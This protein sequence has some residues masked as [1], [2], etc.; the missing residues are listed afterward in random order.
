MSVTVD[1][2]VEAGEVYRRLDI[3][4]TG[5]SSTAWAAW[6]SGV[7]GP[8]LQERAEMR[9][10]NEG[11]DAVGMWQSL[12]PSTI[13]IRAQQ[14]FPP[15]PIN[16]RTGELERLLT[17]DPVVAAPIGPVAELAFPAMP[18]GELKEKL[19]TAQQ[20]KAHPKTPPRPVVGLSGIDL[21]FMLSAMSVYANKVTGFSL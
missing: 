19:K 12:K 2:K 21:M 7:M 5:F 13:R 20:G 18:G 16:H 17:E 10:A 6:L 8:F 11:D 9:F 14:G 1:F 15:G 3:M 4:D